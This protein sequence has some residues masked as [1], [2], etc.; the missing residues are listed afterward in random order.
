[1]TLLLQNLTIRP[2]SVQ[3]LYASY[4][5]AGFLV[6]RRYQRKLV[7]SIE[8]K[9]AFIDSLKSGYPVPL[10]LFA[11]LPH[12]SE[13]IFEIIDGMQRLNAI[14]A[15]LE[16]EF[17]VGGKYFDLETIPE[18]KTQLDDKLL[19]QSLP[20]LDSND[21]RKI[22]TYQ[23][24]L[25][26]TRNKTD[27]EIDEIFRRIN[28]H[29]KHLSRQEL[30]Q[31][32]ST[33]HFAELVRKTAARIRGDVSASDR[34][35]LAKMKQIS[36]TN[37]DLPYGIDVG[38]MFWVENK[39]LTGDQ[40][41]ESRDEELIA[42][43]LG[44]VLLDP[45]PPSRTDVLNEY[46]SDFRTEDGKE[47]YEQIERSVQKHTETS[48]IA[49][50][51]RIH[52][53][54]REILTQSGKPFN[55][56]MFPSAGSRVP[57]YFQVVFLALYDLIVLEGN[58][59]Y[60]PQQLVEKLDGI[61]EKHIQISEGGKWAATERENNVAAVK[62]IIKSAF[63]KAKETDPAIDSWVTEFENILTQS[64]TEN[65]LYEWKQGLHRIVSPYEYDKDVV[66]QIAKT[67]SAMAN[68]GPGTNGYV[69]IG[70]TDDLRTADQIKREHKIEA[71][72]F[73]HFSIFGIDHEAKIA[74][75][76]KGLDSYFQHVQQEIKNQPL[77]VAYR[78]KILSD[79]RL[80]QY[81]DRHIVLLKVTAIDEPCAFNDEYYQRSGSNADK[82]EGEGLKQLFK[83]FYG[84]GGHHT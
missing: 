20:K 13:T 77:T 16:G 66:S 11:E 81:F 42:D 21:C 19:L 33:G 80:F 6:N 56:L 76:R 38:K 2:E 60:A 22:V 48:L 58:R 72:K 65:N 12:G 46:Y 32:G 34:L 61:G 7:W 75:Y 70:V 31:A 78:D 83:R 43:V 29:G 49:R 25:S 63:R 17:D 37:R 10:F 62:G 51:M 36:I 28:S 41:R 73:R 50:Y 57:R 74:S 82:F 54:L 27:D 35:D 45:K 9:R 71:K 53:E 40:V 55:Q 3:S 64:S 4:L 5:A 84:S 30:R 1:M 68:R 14:F 44:Y 52:D 26:V 79:M 47:R 8:E 15:F 69:M 18:T 67:L 39:I 23:C 24:P 59:V